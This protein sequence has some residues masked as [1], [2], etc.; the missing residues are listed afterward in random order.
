[1]IIFFLQAFAGGGVF[2]RIP[3]IQLRLNLSEYMLGV[4][5]TFGA[6]GGL[7]SI[8]FAGRLVASLGTRQILLIGVPILA[9]TQAALGFNTSIFLLFPLLLLAGISF[10]VTNVAMNVEADR[11]ES[12]D[13]K[14]IMNRCHGMWSAGMLLAALVGVGARALPVSPGL[15]LGLVFPVI[16]VLV[17]ILLW[18]MVAAPRAADD[19]SDSRGVALP[20]RRTLLLMLFG[21]SASFAQSSTQN[22]SVIYMRDSFGAPDWVDT[23]TLPAFLIAMTLG[24]MFADGWITRFGASRVSFVL[25]FLGLA[26]SVAVVAAPTLWVALAGFAFIGI[27]TAVQFPLMITAAARSSARQAAESVAAVIFATALVMM[28]APALMGWVAETEGMRLAFA[29]SIPPFLI[30]LVLVKM[31]TAKPD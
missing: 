28:V 23:L 9:A 10:S 31:V 20:S 24:R 12:T 2:A 29:L 21:L 13:G 15:H 30:T 19:K 1:M 6:L 11:V 18:P 17:L 14:R 22:W 5:L 7:I 8:V 27:G 16:T 3:D 26:G 25:T 4:A